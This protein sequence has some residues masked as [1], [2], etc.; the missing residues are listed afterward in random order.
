MCVIKEVIVRTVHMDASL[1]AKPVL[2]L[3]RVHEC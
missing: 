3:N 2:L 1:S